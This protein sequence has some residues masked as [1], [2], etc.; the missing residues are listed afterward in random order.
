VTA[1]ESTSIIIKMKL[2]KIPKEEQEE[3]FDFWEQERIISG[4]ST[5]FDEL[6]RRKEE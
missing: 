3:N 2:K 4:G 5:P 6:E 1:G